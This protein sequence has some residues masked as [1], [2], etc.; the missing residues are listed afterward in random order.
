MHAGPL[1]VAPPGH[2]YLDAKLSYLNNSLIPSNGHAEL[3]LQMC[4]TANP[5]PVH[6]LRFGVEGT[7]L[8]VSPVQDTA[9]SFNIP[10]DSMVPPSVYPHGAAVGN[11]RGAVEPSLVPTNEWPSCVDDTGAKSDQEAYLSSNNLPISPS[12]V[13]AASAACVLS[14]TGVGCFE[15]DQ[16]NQW[17]VRGAINA[18]FS[19]FVYVRS[20]ENT[21]PPDFDQ[22]SLLKA[23]VRP[24]PSSGLGLVQ[25]RSTNPRIDDAAGG[26]AAAALWP[27]TPTLENGANPERDRGE[28]KQRG[29]PH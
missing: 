7:T 22:C 27:P 29:D 17:A 4:S 1:R 16:A 11:E 15:N 18:G 14:T 10:P 25:G 21:G 13:K 28:E 5:P 23:L 12:Q 6:I 19:V 9:N 8:Y 2:G 20:I 26:D 24:G 3:W